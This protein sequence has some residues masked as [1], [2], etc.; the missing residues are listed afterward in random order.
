MAQLIIGVSLGI[1]VTALTTNFFGLK[2]HKKETRPEWERRV[3]AELSIYTVTMWMLL[4]VNVLMPVYMLYIS[5]SVVRII[6][7]AWESHRLDRNV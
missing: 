2:P 5:Y 4:L 6:V 1:L 7:L 3:L